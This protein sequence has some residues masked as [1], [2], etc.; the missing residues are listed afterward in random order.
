MYELY[1]HAFE[2]TIAT[3]RMRQHEFQ[4]HINAIKCMK[5]SIENQDELLIEQERYCDDVLRESS[6]AN[7][8]K[9]RMDP[10]LVGFLYAKITTA[11]DAGI[12]VEYEVNPI[13]IRGRIET[14]EMIELIGG[15]FDN[16]VEALKEMKTRKIMLKLVN[17]EKGFIV[18]VANIS[19]IYSNNEI[20]NFCSYGYSTKAKNRGIGL[21]RIKEIIRKT[22]ATLLIQN[23]SYKNENYLCFKVCFENDSQ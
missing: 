3:I 12:Q 18:E 22:R 7:L 1:N 16:A 13:D 20:E 6:I 10:V 14:Y 21:A 4:N 2:E 15:L 11:Q 8:L 19:R 5:Y 23:Q 9:L 17:I